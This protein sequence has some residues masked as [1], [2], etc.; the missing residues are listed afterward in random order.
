MG[1]QVTFQIELC[2]ELPSALVTLE[3]LYS[4]VNLHVFV[5]VCS[6]CEREVTTFFEALKG[7]FTSVDSKVVEEV[8]PFFERFVT[9]SVSAKQLLNY[10]LRTGIF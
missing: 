9:P 7:P 3:S 4:L 5:K 2:E 6:L 10:A 8:V 1:V